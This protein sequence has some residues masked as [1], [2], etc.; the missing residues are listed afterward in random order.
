MKILDWKVTKEETLII[1]AIAE[2]AIRIAKDAGIDYTKMHVVMDITAV[3][4]NAQKLRLQDLLDAD[5]FNFSYDVF[6]IRRHLNRQTGELEE[7]FTPRFS[8]TANQGA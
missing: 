3:H 1:S 4:K 2:R 7:F 6:G 8:D 5:R